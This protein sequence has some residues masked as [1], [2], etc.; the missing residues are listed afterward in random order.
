MAAQVFI[1]Y[2][3]ADNLAFDEE[4][5]GW[6]TLFVGNLQKAIGMQKG[7]SEVKCWMDHRLEPQREVDDTLHG[8]IKDSQCILAFM[9]PRYLISEWCRK[10]MATFVERVGGGKANDRVF[11]VEL[12]PTD[13]KDWHPGIG[14][15]SLTKFWADAI[16]QP[17]PMTLGWPVPNPK[18]DK[19]YWQGLNALASILARQ[20][21]GLPPIPTATPTAVAPSTPVIE[22][23]SPNPEPAS[24]TASSG[25]FSVVINAD[26]PDRDLGKQI[27]DILVDDLEIDA[28]LAAQP[29]PMQKPEEYYKH[30]KR[31]LEESQGV[32]I[33]YGKAPPSWVQA[34]KSD[35]TRILSGSRKGI[36]GALLDGPPEQKLDHGIKSR[37]LMVLDCRLGLSHDP[38]KRFIDSLRK[39]TD[40]V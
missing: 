40:H 39:G 21:Q 20:I 14:S 16:D 15:I 5:K 12:L 35:A 18:A 33:V 37:N 24:P 23:L 31:Q 3:H 9:S 17:E 25:P 26:K 32:L 1:S 29:M 4:A 34:Q 6:V 30:M 11:L 28:T 19:A 2:A 22:R 13:R 27:Q 10:E 38:L 7:G 36:W 8:L